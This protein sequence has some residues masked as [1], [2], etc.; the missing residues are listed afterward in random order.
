MSRIELRGVIVP[1]IYDSEWAADYIA[2]GLITPESFFRRELAKAATDQP[3]DV[4]I[5]SPGG[6]VF[7]AYEMVNAVRDWKIA[8]GQTV[9]ITV[10]AMAASAASMFAVSVAGTV[11]AHQNAKM[12]FHG[13]STETWGGKGAHEDSVTLLGQI[14]ADIQQVLIQRFNMDPD[15]VAEWFAEG[16]MGWL[17][18]EEMLAAGI[19]SEI[20]TEDDAA[21]DFDDAAVA[22]ID[23]HGLDIA[24]VL[25][26]PKTEDEGNES[27]ESADDSTGDTSEGEEGGTDTGDTG[28]GDTSENEGESGAPEDEAGTEGSY[29]DG[30]AIGR[31]AAI[32]ETAEQMEALKAKLETAEALA[33]KHQSERDKALE[34]VK[35][36]RADCDKVCAGLRAELDISTERLRKYVSGALT[37]S[38][39][40]DSWEDALKAYGGSYEKAIAAHPDLCKAYRQEKIGKE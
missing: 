6:S 35:Q 11:K 27:G 20:I 32:G 7:A 36:T 18:A 25:E 40:V 15:T 4:Y 23:E 30:L 26:T 16:R 21:I 24:A 12:M 10:G 14:N 37:F 34:Q 1:S 31:S 3:L 8:N 29:Q 9:N 13:A 2:K 19:V 22:V 5:N 17:T 33:S 28:Q 38:P 39:S